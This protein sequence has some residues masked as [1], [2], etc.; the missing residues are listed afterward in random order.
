MNE[1]MKNCV[2]KIIYK[3]FWNRIFFYTYNIRCLSKLI[4]TMLCDLNLLFELEMKTG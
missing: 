2:G 3:Y 1:G 4:P